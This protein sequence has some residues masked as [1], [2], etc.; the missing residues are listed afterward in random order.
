MKFNASEYENLP[1]VR[2]SSFY[3]V[4]ERGGACKVKMR[5]PFDD[6]FRVDFS[7]RI[8][9]EVTLYD[10]AGNIIA[11]GTKS[12]EV[13]LKKDDL[14]YAQ[15][16]PT[17]KAVEVKVTAKEHLTQL[18]FSVLE[19]PDAQSFDVSSVAGDPL[20]AAKIEY[21][22]RDGILYA[23]CNSPETVRDYA[24]NKALTRHDVTDREV[25]FT[26]EHNS[27]QFAERGGIFYGYRV[28]NTD[29]KDIYI[30]VK[31]V[32]MQVSGKG[33]FNGELEWTRFYNTKFVLP[34]MSKWSESTMNSFLAWYEYSGE[35][36]NPN[37][38]PA[39]YKIPAG[40][41]MYVLGGTS[42]DSYNGYTVE[43][44][45]LRTGGECQNGAVLFEVKGKAEA[46]FFT[47]NDINAIKN[48]TTSHV[49]IQL[50]GGLECIGTEEGAVVDNSAVWE[51][52]DETP[53]QA[54]PVIYTN[55]YKEFKQ[56]FDEKG[57]ALRVTGEPNTKIDVTPHEQNRTSYY[58]HINVHDTN[59]AVGTDMTAFHTVHNGKPVVI[60][61]EYFDVNGRFANIGNW[62]K[63]YIDAYTF[64]NR[65][66]RERE[67][68]VKIVPVVGG[69]LVIMV[70]D[71]NGKLVAGTEGYSMYYH[72]SKY[73]D[74]VNA[75][76]EYTVKVAPHS[77]T[78]FNV[79]YNLMANSYG[80]VLHEVKLK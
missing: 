24:L 53:A 65:G 21:K 56:E 74:E 39:T 78:Q 13:T 33:T 68:T 41:S 49:G 76:F 16:V 47:Y 19:A 14:V 8:V 2:F 10:G 69:A 15:F 17:N 45:N 3:G 57:N 20:R 71:V 63:D 79:E 77:V 18:P 23:Y 62:M 30:T 40:E 31:N 70:R 27:S 29:T 25:F 64:V 1:E 60:G 7:D 80:R 50:E 9:K 6:S 4:D 5:V 55:Y 32:G 58:T 72:A 73:G 48:D 28:R 75:P 54:L 42:E 36:Q 46:A 59:T 52:N 22:K 38:Q 61:C 37:Y 51:F 11:S 44:A 66:D 43:G 34:D 35:Y 12:F 67:I 26:F